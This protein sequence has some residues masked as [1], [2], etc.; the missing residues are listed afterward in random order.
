MSISKKDLKMMELLRQE[1]SNTVIKDYVLCGHTKPRTRREF[2]NSGLI[3]MGGALFA[4]TLLQLISQSAWGATVSCGGG[5]SPA[6]AVPTTPAFINI[7]MNGGSANFA[8]FIAKGNGGAPLPDYT[9]LGMGSAFREEALFSNSA[10]FWINPGDAPG[11]SGFAQGLLRT[12]PRAEDIYSKSVFIAV[13][14]ES[15]DDNRNNKQDISGML[16]AAGFVGSSLPYLLT[17]YGAFLSE[18]LT[19]PVNQFAG[20]II[21]SPNLLSVTTAASISGSLKPKGALAALSAGDLSKLVK[22]IED[23][24]K[25]EVEAVIANPNSNES[26]KIL[27]DLTYCATEKNTSLVSTGSVVDIS[28]ATFPTNTPSTPLS[29]KTI[30]DENKTDVD[31][32]GHNNAQLRSK[33]LNKDLMNAVLRRTGNTVANCIRGFSG[34]AL[35]NLGGYDYHSAFY[36]RASA[37]LK[38]KFVGDIV[39]RVLK[40]AKAFNRPV[41]IYV[42]ADGSV[43]SQNSSLNTVDWSGDFPKR[44]MNY[45]IAYDPVNGAPPVAGVTVG[46]YSDTSYQLNHFSDQHVVSNVNP[47]GSLDA[48]DLCA[49]AVFLNFLNF[50]KQ[51][52]QIDTNPALAMVKKR[53]TDALPSGAANIMSYYTRIK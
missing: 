42:S 8:N 22:S 3:S 39:G 49:S 13:S 31:G 10:P 36:T 44:G 34:A 11:A 24:S 29:V 32:D 48:Q 12:V 5:G 2:L 9:K 16:Q 6:V 23:L 26:Q 20:A 53:L 21:P 4:P 52:S 7:Q 43:S 38:D 28:D 41:F 27:R 33:G 51:G 15:V 17:G 50:A 19:A 47:I 40:T 45:I 37:E 14:A 35:V 46:S 18:T 25:L 1:Q 30:W